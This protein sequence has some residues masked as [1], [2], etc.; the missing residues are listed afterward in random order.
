MR[1]HPFVGRPL[2][3]L[4]AGGAL[5]AGSAALAPFAQADPVQSMGQSMG[6]SLGS[7]G[8]TT[9]EAPAEAPDGKYIV[10]LDEAASAAYDGGITGLARTKPA[11]GEKL[12]SASAASQAYTAYLDE[13]RAEVLEAADIAADSV[14][15]DYDTSYAGFAAD[16]SHA[17]ATALADTPGVRSVQP[18]ETLQLDTSY[19]PTFLGLDEPGTGLWDQLGGPTDVGG[20]GEDIV[21]GVIDSGFSPTAGSFAPLDPPPALPV[22]DG[23]LGTCEPGDPDDFGGGASDDPVQTEPALLDC[24]GDIYNSKVIG[25]RY[26]VEGVPAPVPGEFVSPKDYDG[27]G[28]HTAS[29]AAGNNAVPAEIA[30]NVVGEISGMAPRARLAVY[31]VCWDLKGCTA[32]DIVAAIDASLADGVD[33]INFSISGPSALAVESVADAF[34]T[35]AEAGV[36]I[37]VSGGNDGGSATVAHNYPWV[38]TTAASSIPRTY[39]VHVLGED[40]QDWVGAGIGGAVGPSPSVYAANAAADGVAAEDAARCF[41]DSLDPAIVSGQIVVCDRGVNP[42][43]EKSAVVAAAGGLAMVLAN[44]AANG[45]SLVTERHS[46]PTAHVS[47]DAGVEVKDYVG[48]DTDN[49]VTLELAAAEEVTGDAVTAPEMASFSSTGPGG[50]AEGDLLKPDITAPGV[51]ILA[52]VANTD[53][54]SDEQY[55]FLSG[56]SMSSPHI[57]GI[58]ALLRDLHPDWSPAAIKSAIVTTGYQQNNQGDPIQALDPDTFELV[59]AT[60]FNYGGGHVDPQAAAAAPAVYDSGAEDWTQF[61]CGAGQLPPTD[62]GCLSA[63]SID[64]S[65]LNYPSIA[66]GDLGGTQTV[67][68]TLT[69]VTDATLDLISDVEL[70]GITATVTP[71]ELTI[72]PGASAEFTVEFTW[73]DA[74]LD[75]YAFGAL[76]WTDAA[77]PDS[78]VRSPIAIQ[79]VPV[80]QVTDLLLGVGSTGEVSDTVQLGVDDEIDVRLSGLEPAQV[81]LATLSDPSSAGFPS[82]DPESC[83]VDPACAPHVGQFSYDVPDGARLLHV[84]LLG[85]DY[86]ETTDL[87]MYVYEETPDGLVQVATSTSEGIAESVS[88]ENPA[89]G[90][91]QIFVELYGLAIGE[92]EVDVINYSWAVTKDDVDDFSVD[93]KSFTGD[94]GESQEVTYSWSDLAVP[95]EGSTEPARY[96]GVVDF[97]TDGENLERSLVRVDVAPAAPPTTAPPTTAP[98]TTAP[99]TPPTTDPTTPVPT[100][101]LPNTGGGDTPMFAALGVGAVLLGGAFI[102]LAARRLRQDS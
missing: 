72:E 41:L 14:F 79:P 49:D 67:T 60:P 25:A 70:D 50:V 46:I 101:T 35:S 62:A 23:W 81:G 39:E 30:G 5:V 1:R 27:H 47:F 42:R 83:F 17:E 97:R 12:N 80:A 21:V 98:P 26:F 13:R 40:G 10:R 87:D 15:Y 38:N 64:P 59:P 3:A 16:L 4:V 19:S 51:S 8:V 20:A 73:T 31:K 82:D 58:G 2:A 74:P 7:T 11:V 77:D 56:T 84:A 65:D 66:I 28:S 24:D 76:T 34:F 96:L 71:G 85:E 92:T 91:Y 45:A 48:L 93:P 69:N 33:V 22:P 90:T 88:L 78:T 68:R 32:A 63:G 53:L 43:V 75:T 36:F 55:G 99:P 94:V 57:A 95:A 100:T 6:Q 54:N 18:N 37:A 102:A 89:A 44:D 9:V 61:L 86:V 52:A 29:T